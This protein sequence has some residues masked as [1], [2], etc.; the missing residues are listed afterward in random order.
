MRR[1]KE[2]RTYLPI[3]A[4][5]FALVLLANATS[6]PL[7]ASLKNLVFDQY[8]RW[9]PR[10]YA[11]DQ[12]VRIIDIDDESIQRIGQWPW[13]RLKMA[14]MVDALVKADVAAISLNVL[15][16]EKERSTPGAFVAANTEGAGHEEQ[17]YSTAS[18]QTSAGD[19][20]FAKAISGRNVVLGSI[21]TA[22]DLGG[23]PTPKVGFAAKGGDPVDHAP[24]FA[25]LL[26]PVRKLAQSASGIGFMNWTPDADRVVRQMPLIASVRGQLEPSFVLESLR[27]AQGASTYVVKCVG[28]DGQSGPAASGGIAEI[29]D[30]AVVVDTQPSGDIRT[31]FAPMDPRRTIPAWKLF[32]EGADLSDLAGKLVI[33]GASASLLSDVVATPLN[34]STPGV[35]AV[36]QLIEQILSGVTLRRPDWAPGVELLTAVALSLALIVAMPVIPAFWSGVMGAVA[37]AILC[38]VSWFAFTQHGL[39]LDPVVPSLSSAVV[40]LTGILTLYSQ[41]RQQVT[42]IRSAFGRY[43]SPAVVAQLAEQPEKLK[44]GGLQRRLTVMFCDIRSFTTISEGFTAA[45]LIHFLNEY[46]TPMTTVILD[47]TGTVDKY[48]GDAIMAFWNA[49][50]DDPDHAVHAVRAALRMRAALVELNRTWEAR[51][52]EAGRPF[53]PVKFGVGLN[54]GDCSVGNMGSNQRFDYSAMGDEV[55]IA[56][57][58][59]G[60]SKVFGVDIVASASTRSEAPGFAWLEIDLVRLKGRTQA[61]PTFALAGDANYA[62][63]LGFRALAERHEAMLEA[64]RRRDFAQAQALAAEALDMAPEEVKGL[65]G[66]YSERLAQLAASGLGESWR[67]M[68]AL[69]EK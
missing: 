29:R 34:P 18:E 53:A 65:Y 35:E 5:A 31:Y 7:Q 24:P 69:T 66:F 51:A 30:G 47:E 60:A 42:E 12:P 19:E 4:F 63:S 15:F 48:M 45:E 21:L 8:E 32:E 38:G 62:V 41:K 23:D 61:T 17:T 37:A 58:L 33:V 39:L 54:T 13:P 11:F 52:R 9:R 68:I 26:G 10:P 55:N 64:Y 40:F 50:L 67:P 27:V 3:V 44:L 57:R 14:E 22:R 1:R 59:E 36:A 2:S 49:P 20:A 46:L 16:S 25:G 43:V 6:T 28:D 56:S